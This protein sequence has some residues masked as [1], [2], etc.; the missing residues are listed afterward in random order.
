MTKNMEE[1]ILQELFNLSHKMDRMEEK[2]VTKE[3]LERTTKE[4]KTE[5]RE[6]IKT[7][8]EQ[9]RAELREEI[10][11]SNEQLRTE[12]REEIKASNEQLRKEIKASNEQLRE[13]IKVSN[14]KLKIELRE[15]MVTKEYF[16]KGMYEQAKEISEV[17]NDTLAVA[18]KDYKKIVSKIYG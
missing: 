15:E 10:K 4:L 12:L 5:L 18:S 7:S 11:T 8:N 13:E 3:E 16:E 14:E 9:L 2:M 17:I 1:I 6:E